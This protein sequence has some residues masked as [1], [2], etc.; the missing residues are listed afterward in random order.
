MISNE[1]WNDKNH[2]LLIEKALR[3]P[4]DHLSKLDDVPLYVQLKYLSSVY[5]L[6]LD[7]QFSHVHHVF[8]KTKTLKAS[9]EYFLNQLLHPVLSKDHLKDQLRLLNVVFRDEY[10]QHDKHDA[11]IFLLIQQLVVSNDID[12]LTTF[13]TYGFIHKS[14]HQKLLALANAIPQI[15]SIATE[16][17]K[18]YNQPVLTECSPLTERASPALTLMT[19]TPQEYVSPPEALFSSP[20]TSTPFSTEYAT[21]PEALFLSPDTS[22]S[23]DSLLSSWYDTDCDLSSLFSEPTSLPDDIFNDDELEDNV[24]TNDVESSNNVGI[25]SSDDIAPVKNTARKRKQPIKS[26]PTINKTTRIK[27]LNASDEVSIQSFLQDTYMGLPTSEQLQLMCTALAK[28]NLKVQAL[29]YPKLYALINE[30]DHIVTFNDKIKLFRSMLLSSRYSKKNKEFIDLFL[31]FMETQLGNEVN[32]NSLVY[33]LLVC[34]LSPIK[35]ALSALLENKC[36]HALSSLINLVIPYR[37]DIL[38][39][40]LEIMNFKF[41][42]LT[43]F[44]LDNSE[45]AKLISKITSSWYENMQ[46]IS[47]NVA[48]S[49]ASI[50]AT[51][52]TEARTSG[53][54]TWA[55][56][57]SNPRSGKRVCRSGAAHFQLPVNSESTPAIQRPERSPTLSFG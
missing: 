55:E 29:F 30:S 40:R 9:F 42:Q 16:L 18:L 37:D 41:E 6:P 19:Y 10:A 52:E 56:V 54:R 32:I 46:S 47:S 15:Q 23:D 20:V 22:A 3:V 45:F 57:D 51:Q 11:A 13:L 33:L 27:A 14:N 34:T 31:T 50:S 28:G 25:D 43:V 36:S 26:N 48:T 4:Q 39:L 1:R 49:A 21:P 38:N 53:K 7:Q 8:S 44:W 12:S 24:T 5:Q 35:S 2:S 17:Y